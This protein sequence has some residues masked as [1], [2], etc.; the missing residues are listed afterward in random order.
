MITFRDKPGVP[1]KAG[2][3]AKILVYIDGKFAGKVELVYPRRNEP[4]W[5][6]L[7]MGRRRNAGPMYGTL[8]ECKRS[9]M[10]ASG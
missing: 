5:R 6:Y 9:L 4:R 10:T 1:N 7:P 8:D 3:C 2:G